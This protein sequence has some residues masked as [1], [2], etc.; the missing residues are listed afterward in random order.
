MTFHNILNDEDIKPNEGY[1]IDFVS[2]KYV[3]ST[4]EEI[5]AVQPFERKLV[6]DLGYSKKQIQTR[7]QF[8]IKKGSQK[9]GPVDIVVFENEKKHPDD[10]YIIVECK[11]NS[12]E[13]GKQQLKSYMNPSTA[14]IGVWFNGVEH[15]YIEKIIKGNKITYRE[16]PNIPRKGKRIEDIG[17]YKRK[18]L[19]IPNNLTLLFKEIRNHLAGSLTGVTRDETI[20]QQIIIL[21][22]CKIYDEI[23]TNINDQVLFRVGIDEPVER[24]R[25]RI[26]KLFLKV[27]SMYN[28]I[29]TKGDLIE[30][31]N[32]ALIYIISQL[33]DYCLTEA[34]RDAIR[35]AFEVFI[36]PALRGSEGQFFTS[37]NVIKMC[38]DII[39]PEIGD[40]IIDPACGSGGFL[41][42]ALTEILKKLEKARNDKKWNDLIYYQERNKII[43]KCL[44]GI[45]KDKFLT[46][47]TKAY[48]A[49]IGN[50]KENIFCENS[51][52]LPVN[53]NQKTQL[54][55]NL[56]SFN[57]LFT[58]PPFGSKIKIK[59]DRILSQYHLGYKWI[60]KDGILKESNNLRNSQAP[61]I[62][63]IERCLQLLKEDGK[64]AIVLPEGLLGNPTQEYIRK[65]IFENSKVL[66]VIDAPI[67]TFLPSTSTKTCIL[68][69]QKKK[70]INENYKI[71]MA[72]AEK[73]GHDSR[74]NIIY[75][76]YK[77]GEYIYNEIGKR[78]IDDDFI[79]ISERYQLIKNKNTASFD[80]NGFLVSISELK[81]HSLI[82]RFYD[83]SIKKEL[84]QL[85]DNYDLITLGDL[86]DMGI[87]SLH[88]GQGVKKKY[89]GTG[90]IP[91]IRTSDITN[92]ELK[93]DPTYCISEEIY[94]KFKQDLKKNDILF[95]MDG[96]R[97]I[98]NNC[99]LSE[100]RDIKCL[101]QSH[102][103]ILRCEKN[104][105][106]NPYLLL[107][108]LNTPIIKKQVKMNIVIQS[109]LATI[110]ER[111]KDIYISIPK[112]LN[113]R[114]KII[115]KT[116]IIIKER[117][118]LRKEIEDISKIPLENTF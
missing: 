104:D 106:L 98:G 6:E 86:I 63:F 77:S 14:V 66:A 73:C 49:I 21:L 28:E 68:F 55:I 67:E 47:V 95:V 60:I 10:L 42:I 39:D 59:G 29:F 97:L 100:E 82:P 33:Q 74:D 80:R 61:Q 4:S 20:A 65:F 72:I 85:K 35:K 78:I 108:L 2:G 58:N 90:V 31:D 116:K 5:E 34:E 71:F 18:D 88:N 101:I 22:F 94:E 27:K 11:S 24:V 44:R 50:G 32:K 1:H 113:I 114:E 107:Y 46:K 19:I 102:F 43:H 110:G 51:L 53:W 26:E 87:L 3:K 62:L 57:T 8:Y 81:S 23:E 117:A 13:D 56:N 109:T 12:R 16:I 79:S 17:K 52:D 45:D 112:D 40:V 41:V 9:I 30:L 111:T 25:D 15:L 48:M 105:K 36:G 37:R 84:E 64:M 69:L 7:P 38:F 92:W 70:V 83:P 89:Y 93:I 96:G 118:K 91:Y 54:S 76:I 103:Q 75:K 99:I 115:N